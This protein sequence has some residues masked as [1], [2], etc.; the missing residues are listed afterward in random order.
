MPQLRRITFAVSLAVLLTSEIAL[1][2]ERAPDLSGLWAAKVRFGPDIRG[3]LTLIR[4][5]SAWRADVAGFSLPVRIEGREIWFELPDGRGSFRGRLNRSEISGQWIGPRTRTSGLSYSTPVTLEPDGPSRW[6]G[7]VKPLD[8]AFTF[9]L[10][11]GKGGNGT[12]SAFLRNPER[13]LGW[14]I[15]VSRMTVKDS[16]VTLTGR[17][18]AQPDA[19]LAEG[20]YEDGILR[21]PLRGASF[22]FSRGDDHTWSPFYPRGKPGQRYRYT[23]PIQLDDGWPVAA[24]EDVGISRAG[25]EAFVQKL[26]D[27]PMDSLSTPQI[28]SLLIARHGKLVVEEYFHG[29]HRDRPHDTR[30]ASKSW[31]AVLLGAAMQAGVPIG[32]NTPVYRTMLDSLPPDLEPRKRAMTLEH[33]IS[34]T[35]GYDCAGESAQGNE[36]V[37]QNQTEEPDWYRY[38]LNVPMLTAPGDTIVYCSIEP[39][40]AAG[41][42]RKIAGE[43]LPELFHRLVARPMR[44]SNYHLFLSPTGEAYGGGGHQFLPRDFLKLPQLMVN[45]GRWNGRRIM[46]REWALKSG[47]ALR[48][49]SRTQQY[50]WLWNSMEYPYR[51]GKVRGLFA[52]GNGGQI[53]MGIP[54]LDLVIGFTGG[55]YNDPTLFIPQREFVPEFILPA[56]DPLPASRDP[57]R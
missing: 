4:S 18:G 44:M 31:T 54:A 25:I 37:M 35:A 41:M 19:T 26:I 50:G 48:N 39:N 22:D 16:V 3:P 52:A 12:Y 46:S 42:L 53:F 34:M 7:E 9:Y 55:S 47:A 28:H 33:L 21:L 36:D 45:E 32:L 5:G 30:S 13:N 24:V 17:R 8:D 43:P 1:A 10:R 27:L 38:T 40:L 14:F 49:L 51:G 23:A 57:Q 15:R 6:R 20:R 2:Q 11:A 56:V 29:Y